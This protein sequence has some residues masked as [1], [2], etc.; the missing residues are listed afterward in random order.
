MAAITP[1]RSSF[2]IVLLRVNP[3]DVPARVNLARALF[4][5][6]NLDEA[7]N[8]VDQVLQLDAQNEDALLV[9]AEVLLAGDTDQGRTEANTIATGLLANGS[10]AAA[11][12]IA[13]E[14]LTS[15]QQFGDAIE[16]FRTALQTDPNNLQ[17]QLGLARNLYYSRQVDDSIREYQKLITEAPADTLPRLELAQIFLGSQ[18]FQRGRSFV[19][20]SVELANARRGRRARRAPRQRTRPIGASQTRRIA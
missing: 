19:Q 17:A 7:R 8:Q 9:R 3:N 18:P 11:S 12:T 2:T 10:N 5:A 4:Y 13:G 16:Q 15:R 1:V 6:N 20:R 14:V